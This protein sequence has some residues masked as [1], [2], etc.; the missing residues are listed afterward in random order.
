MTPGILR[1]DGSAVLESDTTQ[2]FCT[3]SPMEFVSAGYDND[4]VA[5]PPGESVQQAESVP[6]NSRLSLTFDRPVDVATA[7]ADG[8][9]TASVLVELLGTDRANPDNNLPK[10]TAGHLETVDV[11]GHPDNPN[12]LIIAPPDDFY[13]Y[14]ADYRVVARAGSAAGDPPGVVSQ[15]GIPMGFDAEVHF[16]T[17]TGVIETYLDQHCGTGAS[18]NQNSN[19]EIRFSKPL[20]PSSVSAASI[21]LEDQQSSPPQALG[22][23][24]VLS[25]GERVVT[26][27]PGPELPPRKL[28][29][30][31]NRT[32]QDWRGNPLPHRPIR[33]PLD[34]ANGN[35]LPG[36]EPGITVG[37]VPGGGNSNPSGL[38]WA[39]AFPPASGN[40]GSVRPEV[41]FGTG[42]PPNGVLQQS[43]SCTSIQ[44]RN[45]DGA[46]VCQRIDFVPGDCTDNDASTG[47]YAVVVPNGMLAPGSY[48]LRV[49]LDEEIVDMNLIAASGGSQTFA[50][51]D[52][53]SDTISPTI[54][55]ADGAEDVPVTLDAI[56]LDFG[57]DLLPS[58]VPQALS[59]SSSGNESIVVAYAD[60]G[61]PIAGTFALEP[62]GD[63]NCNSG[64]PCIADRVRFMPEAPLSAEPS[65]EVTIS[66]NGSDCST[67]TVLCDAAGNPIANR[68][69]AT[70]S[71]N[72]QAITVDATAIVATADN[73]DGTISRQSGFE[74]AFQSDGQSTLIDP[75]DPRSLRAATASSADNIQVTYEDQSG[76]EQHV[77]G[78]VD[79][80]LDGRAVLF[81]PRDPLPANATLTVKVGRGDAC[82]T[83]GAAIEDVAGNAMST[84]VTQT[85]TTAQ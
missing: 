69:T 68:M 3:G 16:S 40:S 4:L 80:G 15:A 55:P 79:V 41:A 49:G 66:N 57:F 52:N 51:D 5:S 32:V 38:G 59:P 85:F 21:Y 14:G 72:D 46:N 7:F 75:L 42:N 83:Q 22:A 61:D 23:L 24:P 73:G 60:S 1:P 26:L 29:L 12:T 65:I 20:L 44:L 33:C 30:M 35:P 10:C 8:T 43:L 71:T 45:G 37:L 82:G 64:R 31:A 81:A 11:N 34:D 47:C 6:V 58:S 56:E 54:T 13:C 76:G 25:G 63:T 19:V 74:I 84:C 67:A 62:S 2:S 78:C 50:V 36:P 18:L 17:D 77:P 53:T 9:A 27:I 28:Y 39:V 48:T 70:F